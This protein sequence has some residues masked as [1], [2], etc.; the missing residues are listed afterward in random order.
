MYQKM[1]LIEVMNPNEADRQ[2]L[3]TSN[4]SGSAQDTN[5]LVKERNQIAQTLSSPMVYVIYTISQLVKSCR[6]VSTQSSAQAAPDESG[7]VSAS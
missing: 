7:E 5:A 1:P 6:F 4:P 2:S 3:L